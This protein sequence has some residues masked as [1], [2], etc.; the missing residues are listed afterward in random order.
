MHQIVRIGLDIA[1][2]WFQVRAV[3]EWEKEIF[4]RKL[5]RDK[6]LGF[7]GSLPPCEV[8]LEACSSSHHWG[9]EIERL[10]HRVRLISPNYV[11]PF[12]KR[13]KSDAHDV[14]AI[15]E[16]ASRPDMRFVPVKTEEQQAALIVCC[17]RNRDASATVGR[18]NRRQLSGDGNDKEILTHHCLRNLHHVTHGRLCT[19]QR[20]GRKRGIRL[21]FQFWKFELFVQRKWDRHRNGRHQWRQ[22]YGRAKPDHQHQS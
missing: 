9:R 2:R 6:V 7:L 3:D 1:K 17:R 19:I 11:K 10:G 21:R 20:R 14:R 8:A 4:N 12:V 18:S 13:G 16:A 22:R 5:P 15:C